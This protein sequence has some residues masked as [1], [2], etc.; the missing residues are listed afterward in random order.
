MRVSIDIG[1]FSISP[2]RRAARADIR[3]QRLLTPG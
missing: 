3:T 2:I 1:D